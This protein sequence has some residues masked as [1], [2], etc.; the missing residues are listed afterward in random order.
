MTLSVPS[1]V[2]ARWCQAS[3]FHWTRAVAVRPE[4]LSMDVP[5]LW[6]EDTPAI[7][8]V[9]KRPTVGVVIFALTEL[10]RA[11]EAR[12]ALR[13]ARADRRMWRFMKPP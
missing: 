4:V 3:S 7:V 12:D 8:A 6:R 5:W 2:Q 11:G 10:G 9:V 1:H 13:A